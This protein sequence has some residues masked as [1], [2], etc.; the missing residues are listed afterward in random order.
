MYGQPVRSRTHSAARS[1]TVPHRVKR[2]RTVQHRVAPPRAAT[3]QYL[4]AQH[5]YRTAPDRTRAATKK[6]GA[7]RMYV[8]GCFSKPRDHNEL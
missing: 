5:K 3:V 7:I 4:T 2:C 1:N 8:L 6:R